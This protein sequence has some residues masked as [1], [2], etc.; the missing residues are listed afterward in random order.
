MLSRCLRSAGGLAAALAS[1]WGLPAAQP[2]KTR[3]PKVSSDV[4]RRPLGRQPA[5]L[6]PA[7]LLLS[8]Q[9]Q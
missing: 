9:L 1:T 3:P 6:R 8:A 5:C 4:I 2:P 7:D